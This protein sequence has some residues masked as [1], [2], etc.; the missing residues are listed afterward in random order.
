[1]LLRS[2][3]G[4]ARGEYRRPRGQPRSQP[5]RLLGAKVQGHSLAVHHNTYYRWLDHADVAAVTAILQKTS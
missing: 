5:D 4:A 2:P 3:M 1:M